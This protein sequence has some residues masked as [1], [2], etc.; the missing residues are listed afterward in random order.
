[1]DAVDKFCPP[2]SHLEDWDLD[3]LTESMQEIF[4]VRLDL[5]NLE[6]TTREGLE[7]AV[8]A[9]LEARLV[10]KEAEYTPE[11][12]YGVARVIY[13][14]AIDKAWKEHPREMDH[15]REGIGLRGYAQKDPKQE[16]KKEGYNLFASMMATVGTD[17]LQKV[18]RV[19]ITAET[20]DQY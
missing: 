16:Y 14:Q 2:K 11:A 15:L 1:I 13:L 19:H 7:N 3:S 18:F 4:D 12:L 8:Y 10:A 20:E 5:S 17:V 6:D 9:Q